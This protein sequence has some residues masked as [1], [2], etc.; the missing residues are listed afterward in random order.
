MPEQIII[1]DASPLIAL[2]DIG[3]LEILR[4]LYQNI[5]IT[6]IVRNEIHAELPDWI[7]VSQNYDPKQVKVLEL[8]LDA[9]EASAIALGLNTPT[10]T[11]I[12]DEIKGRK[13]AKRL[14]LTVTGTIGIIVKA[15]NQGL[16]KSGREI[17]GSLERHGFWLSHKLKAEIL[18]QM[19]E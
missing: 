11:L 19:D 1:S 3:E 6:D 7:I 12:L 2:V 16:I 18:R 17:L 13:V 15:K 8:E 4:K 14:G 5:T 9:G 10:S